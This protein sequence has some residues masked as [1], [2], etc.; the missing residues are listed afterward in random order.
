MPPPAP[1]ALL[2]RQRTRTVT[3]L[4]DL[5]ESVADHRSHGSLIGDATT[6]AWNGYLPTV[7]CSCGVTFGRWVTSLDA[8]L[9]LLHAASLN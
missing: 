9:D 7:A 3:V 4:V 1:L 5:E 2:E 6:P 8:G